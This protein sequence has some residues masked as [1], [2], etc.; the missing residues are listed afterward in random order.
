MEFN[1]LQSFFKHAFNIVLLSCASFSSLANVMFVDGYVR[2]MPSSV[3]NTAA[4]ITLM[5]H[6][7][8]IKL[9]AVETSVADEVQLHTLITEN[10]VVKMRQKNSFIIAEHGTLKLAPSGDHL[11]LLGLKKPLNIGDKVLLTLKFDDQ[12]QQEISLTVRKPDMDKQDGKQEYHH[13]H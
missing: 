8:P 13:H 2:A 7:A 3:P 4:Y 12:S 9:I 11:M 1:R 5:N 10:G 6:G